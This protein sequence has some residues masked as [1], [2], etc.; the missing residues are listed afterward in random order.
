MKLRYL[1]WALLII[2]IGVFWPANPF[3][4]S[5]VPLSIPKGASA[6]SVE[7][8]LQKNKVLPRPSA[9]LLLVKLLHIQDGIKAGEYSFSPSDPLTR[10]ML[11]LWTG[12]TLPLKEATV[13]FPEGTSIY[14]MGLILKAEGFTH[15]QQFQALVH[16]GISP[17]L[18][19]RHRAIFRYI[20]SE[21]LEGYLFPDTYRFLK[22]ASAEAL[23][24]VMIRRFEEIVLP[25]WD[26]SRKR[27]RL[28]L[29]E[30]ITL[31]S[32]IEKEAKIPSERPVIASVFYNRLKAGMPLAADPTIKYALERPSK[33][34]YLDQL[35]VKSPY[36]T[37]KVRGLPP[38]PICNPGLESIKAAVFPANTDFFFFVAKPD[39]SHL[40]SRT[41]SEHQKAKRK[42][43]GDL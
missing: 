32:I 37:Y 1:A 10:V 28:S 6:R 41:F 9:F 14:K 36:N 20:P 18:R 30:I 22:E 23:A 35:S 42:C 2:L 34:V 43:S 19:E 4:L 21:S 25:F 29:H 26:K 5:S 31:A 39:G 27:T 15:Y 13:T 40:F 33:V 7:E 3:D 8:L 38:G 16:E 24:E 12:E 11:K 17:S